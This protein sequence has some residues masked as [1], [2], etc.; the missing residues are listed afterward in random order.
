[1]YGVFLTREIQMQNQKEREERALDAT[2]EAT[3]KLR[4]AERLQKDAHRELDIAQKAADKADDVTLKA[5]DKLRS[6]EQLLA[7]AR[8]PAP[9]KKAAKK[10][11]KK[12]AKL[13]PK[14]TPRKTVRARVR[15][16]VHIPVKLARSAKKGRDEEE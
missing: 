8:K 2:R 7:K 10:A 12:V 13:A 15:I 1:M 16:P 4:K 3:T 5:K 14:S 11:A 9:A 6:A